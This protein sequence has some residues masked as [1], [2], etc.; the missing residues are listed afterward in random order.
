V[1]KGELALSWTEVPG[2]DGYRVQVT[3]LNTG[4]TWTGTADEARLVLPEDAVPAGDETY[5][6]ILAT[7]PEDLLP[8]GGASVSFKTGGPLAIASHRAQKAQLVS[9]IFA[10]SGLILA[11]VAG[12]S[13][14]SG[15]LRKKIFQF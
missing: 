4:S 11:I 9:Y 6:A 13:R 1:S 14:R 8:P 2:A 12:Y 3:G 7:V 10:L 5:R 15:W